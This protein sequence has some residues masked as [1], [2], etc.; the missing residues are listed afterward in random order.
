MLHQVE[1]PSIPAL[2]L[3][4]AAPPR[5]SERV[6]EG[7]WHSPPPNPAPSPAPSQ[8]PVCARCRSRQIQPSPPLTQRSRLLVPHSASPPHPRCSFSQMPELSCHPSLGR[9]P[10]AVTSF[11]RKVALESEKDIDRASGLSPSPGPGAPRR[12]QDPAAALHTAPACCTP[13]LAPRPPSSSRPLPLRDR[14]STPFLRSPPPFLSSLLLQSSSHS[15]GPPSPS[16]PTPVLPP[17]HPRSLV[18]WC[19]P[20]PLHPHLAPPPPRPKPSPPPPPGLREGQ[21]LSAELRQP[22]AGRGRAGKVQRQARH[23]GF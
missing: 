18:I 15:P 16:L 19:L 1:A 7:A 12:E 21:G 14:G 8:P 13:G 5:N 9:G 10:P 22:P 17:Y 4:P 2:R 6:T 20:P 3:P 11:S 23:R